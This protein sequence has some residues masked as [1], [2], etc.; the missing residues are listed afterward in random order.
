MSLR[1]NATLGRYTMHVDQ[2][3]P[4]NKEHKPRCM[5]PILE[6]AVATHG[7][8]LAA[9]FGQRE[10]QLVVETEDFGMIWRNSGFKLPAFALC[11]DHDH[12]DIP[13]PDFTFGCYPEA[14]YAN[15]S[16]PAIAQLLSMKGRMTRWQ[17]RRKS[18]F[19]RSN[20]GVGPRRGL[21]PLLQNLHQE[22]R[23]LDELGAAL[24][25][26]DTGF[27]VANVDQFVWLDG[28]CENMVQIHTAGFSYSAAL[29]YKMACGS[30]VLKFASKYVEF[31]EPALVDGVHVVALEAEEDGV[32]EEQFFE[33][34]G[35]HERKRMVG[36]ALG[37]K[38]CFDSIM[39]GK[40]CFASRDAVERAG[41]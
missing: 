5:L 37:G 18:I 39:L 24:D 6:A 40:C 19:H 10:L 29:K 27:T 8:D 36:G 31:Y 17:N 28:Q 32:D 4:P 15:S 11:T 13:V 1:Y 30:L 38:K 33:V 25:V 7:A 35:E 2:R 12:I 34:S 14:Q 16:W 9:Q 22:G 3:S 21:M 41:G 23:D 20:W 26:G